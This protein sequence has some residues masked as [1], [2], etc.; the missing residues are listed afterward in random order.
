M[1]DRRE[2]P[3]RSL[4]G[5][6]L[7]LVVRG[8]ITEVAFVELPLGLVVRRL[9]FGHQRVDARAL[10]LEDLFTLEVA[11][12]RECRQLLDPIASRVCFAIDDSCDRSEPTFVTSWVTIR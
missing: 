7:V 5:R 6:T 3:D 11:A 4:T 10:A 12:I 9:R 2:A 1:L 8:D